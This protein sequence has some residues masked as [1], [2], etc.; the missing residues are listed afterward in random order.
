MRSTTYRFVAFEG[1]LS[2]AGAA[3]LNPAHVVVNTTGPFMNPLTS[4]QTSLFGRFWSQDQFRVLILLHELGHQLSPQ[5]G[6]RPDA[7]NDRLNE[8]QSR[9][10][11]SACF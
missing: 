9:K 5:T 3:T 8:A 7:G 10:V 11:T 4:R 2:G 6:F 1:N